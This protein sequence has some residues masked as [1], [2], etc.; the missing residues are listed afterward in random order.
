LSWFLGFVFGWNAFG[1]WVALPISF[2]IRMLL[3]I[4]AYRRGTWARA[5]ATI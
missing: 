1:I 3:G 4:A 2:F 5:G